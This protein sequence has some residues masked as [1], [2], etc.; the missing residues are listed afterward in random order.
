MRRFVPLSVAAAAM[1]LSGCNRGTL[2]WEPSLVSHV[3]DSSTVRF[4]RAPDGTVVD[5]LAL[6]WQGGAPR[7]VTSHGDTLVVP[8]DATTI[9]VRTTRKVG[10]PGTGAII[11]GVI[12]IG[13]S[14]ASCPEPKSECGPT[15]AQFGLAAVGALI[16]AAIRTDHWVRVR[17]DR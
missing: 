1:L 13:V 15:V 5:G 3:P 7:V 2:H 4:S 10:H 9:S 6:G 11:G 16:G 17:W 12:G 14:Y 8:R